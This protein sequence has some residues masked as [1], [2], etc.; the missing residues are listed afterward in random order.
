MEREDLI[1]RGD[2]F[3]ELA[4]VQAADANEMK[5]KI[6][7]IIQAMPAGI[8][9]I[10][11]TERLPEAG[12]IVLVTMKI[13]A[14]KYE[15]EE[16]RNIEFGRISSDRYDREGT[17]WEWLNESGAD[18]WQADWNDSVLAWMP[19]PEPW[20]GEAEKKPDPDCAWK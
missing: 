17:G 10:P 7:S 18:Y 12:K 6:Y 13:A 15:W 1:S 14:H 16:Q 3:N 19:L 4:T 2:L 11:C 9:W 8:K 5:G 20:E